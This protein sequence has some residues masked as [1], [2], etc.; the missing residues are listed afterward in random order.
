MILSN[1]QKT[2]T[3]RP[4]DCNNFELAGQHSTCQGQKELER[5]A[6][7]AGLC[8]LIISKMLSTYLDKRLIAYIHGREQVNI[9]Y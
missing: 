3:T 2:M 9:S 7:K 5:H 1:T 4:K 8:Q 6:I